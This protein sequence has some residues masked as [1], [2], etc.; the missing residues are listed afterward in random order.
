MAPTSNTEHLLT[1]RHVM[2]GFAV[3][4]GL[5]G[6]GVWQSA[7]EATEMEPTTFTEKLDARLRSLAV[8]YGAGALGMATYNHATRE[9]YEFNTEYRGFEASIVKVPIALSVMRHQ[10]DRG[11]KLTEEQVSAIKA[12]VGES[13]NASTSYLFEVLGEDTQQSSGFINQTY[14]QMGITVTRSDEGWGSNLTRPVDQVQ[15]HRTI[16]DGIEWANPGDLEMLRETLKATDDS[17]SWGVGALDTKRDDVQEVFC[18]NGWLP[19]TEGL[20]HLNTAGAV[21]TTAGTYSLC[22][23]TSGFADQHRGEELTTAAIVAAVDALVRRGGA[24]S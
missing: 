16:I 17:Q 14:T 10:F 23:M 19:D 3:G 20:W 9:F 21:V 11:E 12:S 8:E 5:M 13:D 24:S 22:A 2:G 6:L 1:R 18:K 15:I 7:S 4:A